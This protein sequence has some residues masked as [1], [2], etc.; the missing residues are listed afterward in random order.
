MVPCRSTA[1]PDDKGCCMGQPCGYTPGPMWHAPVLTGLLTFCSVLAAPPAWAATPIATNEL[2]AAA[3]ALCRRGAAVVVE[4]L[5]GDAPFACGPVDRPTPPGS[6]FKLVTTLAAAEAQSP[7]L[8]Q[9][10]RCPPPAGYPRCGDAHGALTLERALTVSCNGF[11]GQV[12][13]AVGVAGL[14]AAAR[15]VGFTQLPISIKDTPL[16]A[17]TLGAHGEGVRVTAREMA[18]LLR[19]VATG[20]DFGDGS[21]KLR[22]GGDAGGDGSAKLPFRTNVPSALPSPRNIT[23]AL[24]SPRNQRGQRDSGVQAPLPGLTVLPRLRAALTQAV[25]TGTGRGAALPSVTVAGKTGTVV[26]GAGSVG[27]FAAFAPAEH[28]AAVFVVNQRDQ[29]GAEVAAAARPLLA[30]YFL[31]GAR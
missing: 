12:G 28:P 1:Y 17:A 10:L 29:R 30:A 23:S 26:L 8:G 25:R 22:F 11:F 16:A 3:E 27:W 18:R 24:P 21:A 15:A 31:G 20:Q 14:L 2:R 9:T 4:P 13:A 7:V 19:Y 6:V 5:R